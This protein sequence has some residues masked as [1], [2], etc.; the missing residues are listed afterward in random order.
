METLRRSG[1]AQKM[2]FTRFSTHE[3]EKHGLAN[4]GVSQRLPAEREQKG[5]RWLNETEEWSWERTWDWN[6]S[7]GVPAAIVVCPR[8]SLRA[9]ADLTTAP[10]WTETPEWV[11]GGAVR[12]AADGAMPSV[13]GSPGAS[14]EQREPAMIFM[15]TKE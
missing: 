7:P 14:P 3:T 6:F 5:S 4:G 2:K 1:D 12:W 9:P 13:A 11:D 8:S 15:N 10:D